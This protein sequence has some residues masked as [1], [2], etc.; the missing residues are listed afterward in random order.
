MPT[1]ITLYHFNELS[2]DAKKKALKIWEGKV[3]ADDEVY[4]DI[5]NQ[6]KKRAERLVRVC[7]KDLLLP[8]G[9]LRYFYN[10]RTNIRHNRRVVLDEISMKGVIESLNALDI[11]PNLKDEM[12]YFQGKYG[13][14]ILKAK[15]EHYKRDSYG[16]GCSGRDRYKTKIFDIT[17]YRAHEMSPEELARKDKFSKD[18][19][20]K[21][22]AHVDFVL[23][24]VVEKVNNE[25][26]TIADEICNSKENSIQNQIKQKMEKIAGESNLNFHK[27]GEVFVDQ[28]YYDEFPSA[29]PDWDD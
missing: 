19:V 1:T 3:N 10:E 13:P 21:M 14:I 27:N 7:L 29:S 28:Y 9:D 4:R 23:T 12:A 18:L 15:L 2:D 22:Q 8:I 6:V 17:K 26:I 24:F 25:I 16:W 5:A 20:E 11:G